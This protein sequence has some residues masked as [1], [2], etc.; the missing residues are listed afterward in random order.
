MMIQRALVVACIVA[1]SS[2][3]AALAQSTVPSMLGFWDAV[4]GSHALYNGEIEDKLV[5]DVEIEVTDQT[6]Y[7][8]K[9][10]I[11][12]SRFDQENS[13]IHNGTELTPAAQE[14][15]VGVFSGDG[16]SF[17]FVEHPDTAMSLV[18]F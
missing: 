5:G 13:P 3:N 10:V 2:F 15:I 11:R 18:G 16:A 17:M 8:F 12:W 6:G 9:G 1:L 4:E 7:A 14:S